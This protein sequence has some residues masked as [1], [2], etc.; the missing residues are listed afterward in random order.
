MART[1]TLEQMIIELLAIKLYEHDGEHN[2]P[3]DVVQPSWKTLDREDK[4]AYRQM[5]TLHLP[6]ETYEDEE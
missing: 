4:V 3:H 2:P 5:A 1:A 6:F